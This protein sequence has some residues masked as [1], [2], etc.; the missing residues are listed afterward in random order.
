MSL[1]EGYLTMNEILQRFLTQRFAA[2]V[3]S[4]SRHNAVNMLVN[5]T[6]QALASM[7]LPAPRAAN[8]EL[9]NNP[10]YAEHYERWTALRREHEAKGSEIPSPGAVFGRTLLLLLLPMLREAVRKRSAKVLDI[11]PMMKQFF[12]ELEIELANPR[13]DVCGPVSFETENNR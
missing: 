10:V 9:K 2:S 13:S 11:K 7:N 4:E 12:D 1:S 8:S 5:V 6:T 3:V